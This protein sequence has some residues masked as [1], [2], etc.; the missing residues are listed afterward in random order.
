MY[1]LKVMERMES[2]IEEIK[3]ISQSASGPDPKES[4]I[5][6]LSGKFVKYFFKLLIAL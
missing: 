2:T 3:I 5:L 1:T 4:L 6:L